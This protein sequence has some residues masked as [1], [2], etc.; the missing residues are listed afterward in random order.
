L[1]V[2]KMNMFHTIIERER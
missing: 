1:I 2:I